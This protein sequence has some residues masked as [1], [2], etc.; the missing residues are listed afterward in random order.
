MHVRL[1]EVHDVYEKKRRA[2]SVWT[3]RF[4]QARRTL[5]A[6]HAL[7]KFSLASCS[8]DKTRSS[9]HA[10]T[11]NKNESFHVHARFYYSRI[12]T[13]SA[14]TALRH[15]SDCLFQNITHPNPI[16]DMLHVPSAELRLSVN[17]RFLF[18]FIDSYDFGMN[19]L[20]D[21]NKRNSRPISQSVFIS[22]NQV[23]KKSIKKI[24]K[25]SSRESCIT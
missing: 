6:C 3:S 8:A 11:L 7:R 23:K 18:I 14:L 16:K 10:S 15:N 4:T 5:T 19:K 22:A 17:R 1:D 2:K 20:V 24:V 12:N 25:S 21:R 13:L 9:A